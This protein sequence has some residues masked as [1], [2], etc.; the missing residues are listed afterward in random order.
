LSEKRMKSQSKEKK[1]VPEI[2]K[3]E[4][5]ELRNSVKT[6]S[7][8]IIAEN[9]ERMKKTAENR[10]KEMEYFDDIANFFGTREKELSEAKESGKKVIGYMCLFA[11][12]ELILAADAI[13]IRV[14]SGWY[15]TAKLGDR[16]VPVEVCPVVRSTIGAKMIGLSPYLELSD[17]LISVLTCDGMTK[18]GEI[19]SDYKHVWAM[20]IPRVKDSDQSLRFWNDE[21][22]S[23]KSQI[24]DLTGNKIN[25]KKLLCWL[26]KR[27]C[28]MT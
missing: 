7:E 21:I 22:K 8:K 19:L 2:S 14:N 5:N 27:I 4:I 9:I 11:P 26:I 12:T 28:G 20:T 10:P 18:L 1:Y 13:P 3:K 23:M 25:R 24:E 16:V 15:D 6:A 17:A